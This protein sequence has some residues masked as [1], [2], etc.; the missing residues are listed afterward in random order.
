MLGRNYEFDEAR[1]KAS[2]ECCE[3]LKEYFIKYPFIR[4]NQ[5]IQIFQEVE[6]SGFYE[7]PQNTLEKLKKFI[8]E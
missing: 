8:T 1:K 4:F 2:I 3:L 6:N 7:E 5:A